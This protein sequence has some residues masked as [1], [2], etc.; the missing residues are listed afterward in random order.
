MLTLKLINKLMIGSILIMMIILSS[1]FF[2][3]FSSFENH[4]VD[5]I[6]KKHKE[7][8]KLEK[9]VGKSINLS[10]FKL[11]VTFP[12]IKDQLEIY[13]IKPRFDCPFQK[14]KFEAKFKNSNKIKKCCEEKKL[15]LMPTRDEEYD[16]SDEKTALSMKLKLLDANSV[17]VILEADLKELNLEGI[18]QNIFDSFTTSISELSLNPDL[19]NKF[20]FKILSFCK[21][22]GIDHFFNICK[23]EDIKSQKERLE[24]DEDILY[25]DERDILI[26]KDGKWSKAALNDDTTN[27]PL[28]KIKS[29]DSKAAIGV[30]SWNDD[31][32]NY[33]LARIKSINSKAIEIESWDV[34]GYNKYVFSIPFQ[35]KPFS[36]K[37][38][39]LISLVRKRTKTHLSCMMEKQRFVL[40]E[41]DMLLKRDGRWKLLKKD[42]NFDDI[43]ND[44]LFYFEKIEDRNSRKFL[45]G[46]FFNP[47]RTDF[48]K[49]EI[50]I[51]NFSNQRR[52]RKR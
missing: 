4:S 52:L 34:S 16:F 51:V 21:W 18:N 28:A 27:Y 42:V 40:K 39:Q 17:S 2:L 3:V 7:E 36:T 48:Q 33:P 15:Y 14:V 19:G 44:E 25:L 22:W 29:I 30:E 45:I 1:L 11:D 6:Q 20:E 35:G 10:K 24:I 23:K 46:Y 32:T 43:L 26:F 49:V 47:M 38:D 41:K 5:Y 12:T 8:K 31:T 50:P 37:Y 9:V 13:A